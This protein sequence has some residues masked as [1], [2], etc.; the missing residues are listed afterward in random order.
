MVVGYGRCE[1]CGRLVE[2][3]ELT[4]CAEC[5]QQF[6][7]MCEGGGFPEKICIDCEEEEEES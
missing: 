2:K 6:C 5:G 4:K 7:P 3:T 1:I